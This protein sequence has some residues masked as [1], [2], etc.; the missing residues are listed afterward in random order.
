MAQ[1]R[2]T[3]ARFRR[4]ADFSIP[5]HLTDSFGVF[6]GKAR[7]RVRIKFDAFAARLVSERQWHASQKI[8]QLKDGE[9]ELTVTLGGLE[10]IERWVLSW[11]D[12]ACV[13]EPPEL[14]RLVCLAAEAIL[15]QRSSP[16]SK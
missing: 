5:K 9:I 13:V 7:H 12:H 10:E 3:R 11:G 15:D 6:T 14:R 4:S 1:V 8:K 2:D 16:G